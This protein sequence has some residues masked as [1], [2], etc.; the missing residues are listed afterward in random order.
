VSISRAF[1]VFAKPIGA[2]CN[3]DCRYCYYLR[4]GHPHGTDAPRRMPADLL[5][6]YI[7]QHI[8]ASAAPVI[9][10]AWHGGEPTLAGLEFFRDVV[11]LQHRHLPP[12]RRIAN[13]I[14]TNG[15]LIDE[16][17]CRLL[18]AERFSVGLSLDGAAEHHD[19]YRVTK[20]QGPTHARVLHAFGLL[21]RHHVPCDVLCVV[22]DRNVGEPLRVYRFLKSIG[23]RSLT[24]LPLVEPGRRGCEEPVGPRSVSAAAYGAFLCAIF[25]EWVER[26]VPRVTVQAFDEATRPA[27]GLEHSLCIFR[28][29]CGD[30]PV[31]ERNGDVYACDH[32]VDTEHRI[33]NL[34][35]EPFV[36]LLESPAQRSFG[37]A[38]RDALPRCCREC[39]V[40]PMCNGGCPKDRLVATTE[41]EPAVNYLCPA[42]KQFFAHVQPYARTLAPAR[43]SLDAVMRSGEPAR[44]ASEAGRNDPCPCGSGRKYKKCC[45]R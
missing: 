9:A 22:H 37:Q 5:E 13:G 15:L 4:T 28:E 20:G 8:E 40:L 27:R 2:A 31:V 19:A 16:D 29:T 23:A 41:G 30:V 18:A 44:A 25:D 45:G 6:R 3:L 11:A 34:R 17:W 12:G 42:F 33:G 7:A 32:Y 39:E 43:P 1:Q 24:F 26:D 38:K 14:Q 10:F 35:D 36:D 21:R